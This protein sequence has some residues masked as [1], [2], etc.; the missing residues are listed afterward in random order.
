M[1]VTPTVAKVLTN[2]GILAKDLQDLEQWTHS[3]WDND[4]NG[5]I[6]PPSTFLSKSLA[7]RT[8]RVD[9]IPH[10]RNQT[11]TQ[12]G[13]VRVFARHATEEGTLLNLLQSGRFKPST[14]HSPHA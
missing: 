14:Q 5:Y 2:A 8:N 11:A 6:P 10:R 13:T 1:P 3:E 9:H 7:S 12:H 4:A